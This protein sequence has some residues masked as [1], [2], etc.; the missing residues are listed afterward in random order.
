MNYIGEITILSNICDGTFL[1]NY[2]LVLLIHK[3]ISE[4]ND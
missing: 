3:L 2:Q 1:R 4:L